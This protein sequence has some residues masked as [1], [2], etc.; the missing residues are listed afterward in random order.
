MSTFCLP[1]LI[2][3]LC[4]EP[5]LTFRGGCSTCSCPPPYVKLAAQVHQLLQIFSLHPS[6][7]RS[8]LITQR[9]PEPSSEQAIRNDFKGLAPG[10]HV[11]SAAHLLSSYGDWAPWALPGTGAPGR[12]A[13]GNG[14]GKDLGSA[15]RIG[16]TEIRQ[17]RCGQRPLPT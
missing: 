10:Q 13:V 1:V 16:E 14:T 17:Q 3:A 15:C 4:T 8:A 6:D 5:L 11:C 7:T 2:Q 12:E 9:G